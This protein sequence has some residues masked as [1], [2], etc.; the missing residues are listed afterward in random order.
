M[1]R[2]EIAPNHNAF[3]G[4]DRLGDNVMNVRQELSNC[5]LTFLNVLGSLRFP[6]TVSNQMLHGAYTAV[7]V[8]GALYKFVG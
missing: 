7:R 3:Y 1:V 2:V 4:G 5:D 6:I 8:S